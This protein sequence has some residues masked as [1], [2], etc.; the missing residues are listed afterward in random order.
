MVLPSDND[1]PDDV[2][3]RPLHE[4]FEQAEMP[5]PAEIQLAP[6]VLNSIWDSDMMITFQ[7]GMTG[8]K[9]WQCDHCGQE[10]FEH[11]PRRA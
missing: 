7:N 10:W 3:P 1:I 5:P 6:L 8:R 11:M 2:T 9:K 4:L